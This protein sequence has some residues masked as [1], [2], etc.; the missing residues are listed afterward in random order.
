MWGFLSFLAS[1]LSQRR[2]AVGK[3]RTDSES[4]LVHWHAPQTHKCPGWRWRL[5]VG[6]DT[7]GR[8]S[9]PLTSGRAANT[10][11][12]QLHLCRWRNSGRRC[13]KKMYRGNK[14]K[15]RVLLLLISQQYNNASKIEEFLYVV[16]QFYGVFTIAVHAKQTIK[17]WFGFKEKRLP[18]TIASIAFYFIVQQT[19][20]YKNTR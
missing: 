3:N 10:G 7:P 8:W 19:T 5:C 6:A 12:W 1:Y 20:T 15:R 9:C 11:S 13:K 16:R 17:P 18:M 14:K 2:V 4:Q